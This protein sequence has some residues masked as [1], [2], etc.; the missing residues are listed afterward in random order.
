MISGVCAGFALHYRWDINVT[1]IVTA[2]LILFTGIFAFVYIA[3]WIIIPE[4]PYP[5]SPK[6]I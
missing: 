2:L 5:A 4:E 3:A 1:R 6:S